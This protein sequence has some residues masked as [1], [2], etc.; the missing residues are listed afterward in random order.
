MDD[1]GGGQGL[2]APLASS[3]FLV[4]GLIAVILVGAVL[5]WLAAWTLI[6]VRPSFEDTL[7][8]ALLETSSGVFI[9]AGLLGVLLAVRVLVAIE[10]RFLGAPLPPVAL[11]EN[12]AL[13][14]FRAA[15]RSPRG[16]MPRHIV[17]S[18]PWLACRSCSV[19]SM[20]MPSTR[21]S[22]RDAVRSCRPTPAR[23]TASRPRRHALAQPNR[24]E[25]CVIGSVAARA[26]G[27]TVPGA[28]RP[29]RS[30]CIDRGRIRLAVSPR[31]DCDAGAEVSALRSDRSAVVG[32]R[33]LIIDD[34]FTT[35]HAMLEVARAFRLA[36]GRCR[37]RPRART[38]TVAAACVAVATA[39]A[40]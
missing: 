1:D 2:L 36:G 4:A 26:R 3:G 39:S 29:H 35:G 40:P 19:P 8:Q 17:V 16:T 12:E 11:P 10:R 23:P 33:I 25:R 15:D 13:A 31:G 7:G 30:S 24:G 34:V 32:Q 37:R 9:G 38:S 14:W 20:K 22:R 28:G 27:L 5:Y 6:D 21:T 18:A